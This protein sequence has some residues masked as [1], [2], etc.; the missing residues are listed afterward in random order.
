[1]AVNQ[2]MRWGTDFSKIYD[3]GDLHIYTDDTMHFDVLNKADAMVIASNGAATF[4]ASITAAGEITAYSDARLKQNVR[5][6]TDATTLLRQL[7]GVRFDW[8]NGGKA[9]VGLIAQEVQKVLP[10]VVSEN[11]GVTGSAPGQPI[12]SLAYGNLVALLIEALK[13]VLD[14]LDAA[15]TRPK[16]DDTHRFAVTTTQMVKPLSRGVKH[17]SRDCQTFQA[18]HK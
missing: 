17:K 1:M 8:K 13:H 3:N 16:T 7:Q 6:I 9:S 4:S 5:P 14:R 10:E 2:V 15:E 11:E 12:L 18:S